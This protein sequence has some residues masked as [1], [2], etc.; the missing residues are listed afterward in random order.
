[1]ESADTA[2]EHDARPSALRLHL[3]GCLNAVFTVLKNS[4][5]QAFLHGR[6]NR[7]EIVAPLGS[8]HGHGA[9]NDGKTKLKFDQPRVHRSYHL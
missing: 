3:I 5:F 6:I 8:R 7:V 1:M 9:E 2:C 4:K